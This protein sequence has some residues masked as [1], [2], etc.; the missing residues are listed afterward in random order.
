MHAHA[1]NLTILIVL[2]T[3]ACTLTVNSRAA[4]SEIAPCTEGKLPLQHRGQPRLRRAACIL[5]GLATCAS[6]CGQQIIASPQQQHYDVHQQGPLALPKWLLCE[7]PRRG[8]KAAA[9]HDHQIRARQPHINAAISIPIGVTPGR[10]NIK[11]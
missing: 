6:Q 8:A 7:V 5:E 11:A 2:V 9:Q 3:C 4:A 1:A 10:S